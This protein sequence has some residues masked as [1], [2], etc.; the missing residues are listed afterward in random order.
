MKIFLNKQK[1]VLKKYE[2][3]ICQIDLNLAKSISMTEVPKYLNN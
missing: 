2:T 3:N 1:I